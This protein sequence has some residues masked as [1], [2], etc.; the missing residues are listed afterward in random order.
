MEKLNKIFEKAGYTEE[1]YAKDMEGHEEDE[2]LSITIPLEYRL[3][4]KGLEATVKKNMEMFI[5]HRLMY[6]SSLEQHQTKHRATYLF[7]MVQEH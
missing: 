7:L 2:S 3:T 5:F 4:D 6:Y 1:D